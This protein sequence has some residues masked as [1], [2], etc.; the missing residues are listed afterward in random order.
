MS[1]LIQRALFSCLL[2]MVLTGLGCTTS[3]RV[4]VDD[5]ADFSSYRTWSWNIEPSEHP[6]DP[7]PEELHIAAAVA[8]EIQVAMHARGFEYVD[9]GADLLVVPE[10]RITRRHVIFHRATNA[11]Y[12]PSLHAS[13]SYH[14]EGLTVPETRVIERTVIHVV[15]L[16]RAREAVVWRGRLRGTF[17]HAFGPHIAPTVAE[18]MHPL[19][20]SDQAPDPRPSRWVRAKASSVS[21][22]LDDDAASA[23]P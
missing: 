14:I 4:D 7:T 23:K 2:S 6:A 18:L 12:L 11:K 5:T 8:R 22:E 21:V 20:S 3:L 1:A 17:Q 19:P 16:D 9:D 13:P 10:L 15:I